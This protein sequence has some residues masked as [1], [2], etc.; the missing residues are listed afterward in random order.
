MRGSM[1]TPSAV[2]TATGILMI[3]SAFSNSPSSVT[4]ASA[5]IMVLSMTR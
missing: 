3:F 2:M 5:P 1:T 4:E